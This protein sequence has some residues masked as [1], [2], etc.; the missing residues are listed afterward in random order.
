MAPSS[1]SL[2]ST[3]PPQAILVVDDD[4]GVRSIM[5]RLITHLGFAVITACDGTSALA[6]IREEQAPI[7]CAIIDLTMPGMH[8]FEVGE[9]L[10]AMAP[11]IPIVFMSGYNATTA[12]ERELAIPHTDFLQKPFAYEDL[13]QIINRALQIATPQHS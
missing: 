4:P 8:G 1:Q 6:V 12:T 2:L 11:K 7:A 10:Y 13:R 9:A 3:Q 5:S